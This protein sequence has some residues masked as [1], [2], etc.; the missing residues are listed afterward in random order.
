MKDQIGCAA[1]KHLRYINTKVDRSA[2]IKIF[3]FYGGELI[4]LK[5]C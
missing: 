2:A 4:L 5:N 1:M 3:I